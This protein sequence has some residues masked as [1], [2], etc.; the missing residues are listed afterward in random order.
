M[1]MEIV[2]SAIAVLIA[3]GCF[4]AI[5]SSDLQDRRVPSRVQDEKNTRK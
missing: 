1:E 5:V 4:L 3:A 2:V